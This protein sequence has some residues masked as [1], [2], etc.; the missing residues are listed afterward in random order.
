MGCSATGCRLGIKQLL[1]LFLALADP[2]AV[3]FLLA[4]QVPPFDFLA[5][6][7]LLGERQPV[8]LLVLYL[9]S[10]TLYLLP[11]VEDLLLFVAALE[12]VLATPASHCF[13]HRGVLRPGRCWRRSPVFSVFL[14]ALVLLFILLEYVP[15]F[16]SSGLLL[17]LLS[18][19]LRYFKPSLL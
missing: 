11:E 19:R 10:E 15:A 6:L 7:D 17:L 9:L 13:L 16:L 3:N 1:L 5:L 8:A 4:L 18:A 12:G 2:P 14:L